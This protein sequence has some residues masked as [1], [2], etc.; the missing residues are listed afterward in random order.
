VKGL[1]ALLL[2]GVAGLLSGLLGIG[3]GLIVGPTLILFGMP[4]SRAL[5]TSLWVVFPVAT[6]AVIAEL[7]F[8]PLQMLWWPALWIAI[9]GQIGAPIGAAILLRL[10]DYGLRLAF[11]FFLFWVGLRNIGL[12]GQGSSGIQEG[13]RVLNHLGAWGT[14]L[15]AGSIGISAGICSTL[16]GV[17][18]GVVVVPG[19]LYLLGGIAFPS[20]AATSLLAMVPTAARG[21]WLAR[22]QNRL[23]L[24]SI[25]GLVPSAT[26]ATF[27]AV[28]LRD[29]VIA[30]A[31][32]TQIFG[33]FLLFVASR[34]IRRN[35]A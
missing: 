9:G 12:L 19:L 13:F 14:P 5:G 15:L 31:V 7:W 29:F 33:A 3:G 21:A 8:A 10:P 6:A 32:L 16:F 17:G 25:K 22:N 23:D 18:G 30:P 35:S 24:A 26:A 34:L 1:P 2:G 20:A 28:W 4:A 27:V 11:A